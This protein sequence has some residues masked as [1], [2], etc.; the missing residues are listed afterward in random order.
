LHAVQEM[1]VVSSPFDLQY[2]GGRVPKGLGPAAVRDHDAAG[3]SRKSRNT[4]I[5]L[6]H[7]G[8]VDRECTADARPELALGGDAASAASSI[9]R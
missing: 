9:R 1:E 7:E 3:V 5:G 4:S 2:G 6:D 8:L